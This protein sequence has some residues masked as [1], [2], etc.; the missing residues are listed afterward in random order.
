MTT[1]SQ[2]HFTA[3]LESLG[4]A[5]VIMGTLLVIAS[6]NKWK[7]NR[8]KIKS[9]S[10]EIKD[11]YANPTWVAKQT[12]RTGTVSG[13]GI[14]AMLTP[15]KDPAKIVTA[16]H[17]HLDALRKDAQKLKPLM[18]ARNKKLN[19]LIDEVLK[20]EDT[21]EM[22]RV[23]NRK[24]KEIDHDFVHWQIHGQVLGG[25]HLKPSNYYTVPQVAFSG[26][27]SGDLPALNA[28]QIVGLG[29]ILLEF[30]EYREEGVDY[31]P[32]TWPYDID[33]PKIREFKRRSEEDFDTVAEDTVWAHEEVIENL[34]DQDQRM[35]GL[36]GIPDELAES[37][38][39]TGA[40]LERWIKA[41]IV[42]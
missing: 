31:F 40:A 12:L 18:D 22:M 2:R 1:K 27:A 11:T 34:F 4:A 32:W 10:D 21:E 3:S 30:I 5:G 33:S 41:S 15:V 8:Q 28:E 7:E 20:I 25:L 42:N 36:E 39:R 6:Y 38:I 17:T 13:S 16:C 37:L 26:S 35:G 19:Q 23:F 24:R 14:T 29:K 9:S